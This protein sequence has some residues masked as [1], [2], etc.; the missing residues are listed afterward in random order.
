MDKILKP[1]AGNWPRKFKVSVIFFIVINY[2]KRAFRAKKHHITSTFSLIGYK[3]YFWF[4]SVLIVASLLVLGIS[5]WRIISGFGL[6]ILLIGVSF[7][8]LLPVIFNALK[9]L[10][11]KHLTIDLLA[12]V[13]LVFSLLA[14]QW[15]SAVFIG[16]M[17]ASARLFARYTATRAKEAISSLMK[18]RPTKVHQL[19]DGKVIE[20]GIDK[21]KVGDLIAVES[22]DR[23]AVDGVVESGEASLD[24]STLTGES[25]PILKTAGDEVLSSTLCINGSL[26]VRVKRVGKETVFSKILELV[27][28]SQANKA[29]IT[30]L[31]DRFAGWYI[32]LTLVASILIYIFTKNI[33]LV[34]AIL[35]VTC[36]DDLAVAI[37]LAFSAAIGFMA[38]RGIIVKGGEF[39]EG[40]TKIKTVIF[41]KT[42]TITKGKPK[43][44]QVITFNNYPEHEFL[45]LLGA[46]ESESIHPAAR[47]SQKYIAEQKINIPAIVKVHEEPGFGIK[48]IINGE[49]V[50][51]GKT[52][53]LKDNGI[54]FSSAELEKID[55]QK[56][57]QHTITIL[58]KGA[59]PIGFVAMQDEIRPAASSVMRTLKG[60]GI[61][62]I[63]MLTGDNDKI[64]ADVAK[65][66][67]ISEFKADLLPQHKINILKQ[68]LYSGEKVAMVGDGVNDAAALALADVGIAMGAIGSDAAIDSADIVLMKDK[69]T[70]IPETLNLS[71]LILKIIKQDLWLWGIVNGVGLVLVF[72]GILGPS[73]AA[74]YNFLTDF[75]PL[76]NSMRIFSAKSRP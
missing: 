14:G 23:V 36:A 50:L 31:V 27:E 32:F 4:D 72:L 1:P 56:A 20:V 22:G 46:V 38:R 40:L 42:G 64:A 49:E 30:S 3:F 10:L 2:Q 11:K 41:D 29:P 45:A 47:A 57:K 39:L 62:R 26:V 18:L 34:L 9:A 63:L 76:L 66:V 33:L 68:I 12:S 44:E 19:Q 15:H 53:F 75:L 28:Q 16:L 55:E 24:Q 67:G 65:H 37:P 43:I 69:L 6:N 60:M 35:L 52:K 21:I 74:A 8:G 48:G 54:V 61:K 13:A 59:K 70:N 17:L 58:S 71:R 5:F 51:A 73:G 7:F 25:E